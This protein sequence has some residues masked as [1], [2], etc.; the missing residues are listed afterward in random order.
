MKLLREQVG[1]DGLKTKTGIYKRM[2]LTPDYVICTVRSIF[3]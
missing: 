3:T 1:D 2:I